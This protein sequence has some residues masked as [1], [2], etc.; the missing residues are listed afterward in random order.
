MSFTTF[1]QILEEKKKIILSKLRG[2]NPD[3]SKLRELANEFN[4]NCDSVF[5]TDSSD[6]DLWKSVCQI[7]DEYL[8]KS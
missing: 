3:Y 6:T 5:K 8:K 4:E 1:E 2:I 7:T